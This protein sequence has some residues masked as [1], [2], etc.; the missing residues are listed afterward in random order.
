MSTPTTP[1]V[2]AGM[3]KREL[4]EIAEKLGLSGVS[5]LRKEELVEA[6]RKAVRRTKKAAPK[7]TV[8]KPKLL[9]SKKKVDAAPAPKKARPAPKP[10]GGTTTTLKATGRAQ[11]TAKP[12]KTKTSR[13]SNAAKE[14]RPAPAPVVAIEAPRPQNGAELSEQSRVTAAKYRVGMPYAEEDL[15]HVDAHLP[16]LPDGY[17]ID[18]LVLLPRDPA[19]LYAYWDLAGETRDS[20][21]HRGGQN[22]ALRLFE[23]TGPKGDLEPM[24]EHWCQEYARSWYLPVP[25]PGRIY[26]AEVGYRTAQGGWIRLLQSNEVEAPNAGPSALVADEFMTIALEQPLPRPGRDGKLA[27]R[28]GAAGEAGAAGGPQGPHEEAYRASLGGDAGTLPSG[29]A[30]F[31]A[32]RPEAPASP[33]RGWSAVRAPAS[34]ARPEAAEAGSD[35]WLLANAELV[36]FGATEP[37]ATL[38]VGGRPVRLRP[39]GT[40]SLRMAFP[41]GVIDTPISAKSADGEHQRGLWMRFER[42]S[43][44]DEAGGEQ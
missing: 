37:D 25:A 19:W 20:A 42:L 2:Y 18:R 44:R 26:V 41:D 32:V 9:Q 29:S 1:K 30:G 33:G 3:L 24:A 16:G 11:A 14:M 17:G 43:R 34:E 36:V 8:K 38:M 7:K 31:S 13:P 5:K 12:A 15:R 22:L 21:R 40:F 23:R 28:R 4:L 10:K 35:F 39:D 27:G 6:I